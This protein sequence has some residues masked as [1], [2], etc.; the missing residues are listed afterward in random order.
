MCVFQRWRKGVTQETGQGHKVTNPTEVP[1]CSGD[2]GMP[3]D[4]LSR[5]RRSLHVT[6][7]GRRT[8]EW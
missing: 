8:T 6:G 1:H 4:I 2:T 3:K 5:G 7:Q